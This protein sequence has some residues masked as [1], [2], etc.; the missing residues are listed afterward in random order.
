MTAMMFGDRFDL[1]HTCMPWVLEL[2]GGL[3]A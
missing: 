1:G 3:P 2:T